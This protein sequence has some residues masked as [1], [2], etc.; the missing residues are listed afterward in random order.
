MTS[1]APETP[2]LDAAL[3][4]ARRGWAVFPVNGK[5]PITSH[6][7]KDGTTDK[8]QIRS[9][10]TANPHA[11]I[12]IATGTP[13]GLLVLDSDPRNGGE[14]SL[15]SLFTPERP[16]PRTPVSDTGGGGFHL[17]FGLPL[18]VTIRSS[19]GR[20]GPGLDVKCEGGYVVGP[21]SPHPNGSRYSWEPTFD[22]DSVP[23]V[24]VP[25]WLLERLAEPETPEARREENAGEEIAEGERN[26][27]LCSLAGSMRRR[28]A[29][30][31]A[32]FAA[33]EVENTIRCRPP[34]PEIEVRQIAKSV[35]GYPALAVPRNAAMAYEDARTDAASEATLWAAALPAPAFLQ[36]EE[37]D[38]DFLEP[39]ILASGSITEFFSPRGLGKT[40]AAHAIAVKLARQGVRLLLIDRDNSPREIKRRL[41]GW[42]ATDVPSLKVLTRDQ[43]PPLT[44]TPAWQQFPLDQYDVVIIDSLD[45][46]SEG[47]GE[48]D[49][50]KPSRAL[51]SIL[52]VA[53]TR[54]GPAILVLGN[55]VKTAKHS[56]G[57]G[58]VEDR[59]DI[60]YEV[61]DATR[62]TPTGT[63][64]WFQEL[65]MG[66]VD[67]WQDRAAR[68]KRLDSYR[69][70]FV[71]T[72][73]RVG[74]EPEPFIL[75][76]SLAGSPWTLT[77]VTDDVAKAGEKALEDA[78]ENKLVKTAEAVGALRLAVK[79]A[80]EAGKPLLKDRDAIPLLRKAG[81]TKRDA[82][83]LVKEK[84]GTDWRVCRPSG[85]RGNPHLLVPIHWVPETNLKGQG[86]NNHETESA[87]FAEAPEGSISASRS[88]IGWRKSDLT[89]PAPEAAFVELSLFPPPTSD[90]EP[91]AESPT[92]DGSSRLGEE[93]K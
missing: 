64:P 40:H 66:G 51:A 21:P 70:G 46:S 89:K 68:R 83:A 36:A 93:L 28:G 72:K 2:L 19:T 44:D 43:A 59:A 35:S 79:K 34:L 29:S 92:R 65:P 4:Y 33:L 1:S 87:L 9:R 90:R 76:I 31:A 85:W 75:E 74:E 80:A 14:E 5:I 12:G 16:M 18:G 63:K 32:I 24:L 7:F 47:V 20:L 54:N 6:G 11:G 81:L 13:S 49:S 3:A 56:R 77:D 22:P 60:V 26:K 52:D 88:N 82:L 67:A 42:G 15:K 61:R 55:T 71:P 53:R 50:A 48:Q 23:L 30:E 38:I 58:V 73:F 8:E 17:Y 86:G 78:Q 39:R 84:T 10:W 91:P 41:K 57:S 45:S 62:F 25:D 27:R 69:L 37:T